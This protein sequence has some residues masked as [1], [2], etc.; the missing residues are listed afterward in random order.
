MS[1]V[2]IVAEHIEFRPDFKKDDSTTDYQAD[3]SETVEYA[4]EEN[5]VPSF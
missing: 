3:E 5:L 4:E 1:K 2:S